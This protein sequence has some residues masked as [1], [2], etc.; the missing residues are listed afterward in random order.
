MSVVWKIF[1]KKSVDNEISYVR[2]MFLSVFYLP[3]GE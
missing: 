2:F 3:Y 1:V